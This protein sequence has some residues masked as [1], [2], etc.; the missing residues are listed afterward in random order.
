MVPAVVYSP[1][2]LSSRNAEKTRWQ[3]EIS[4]TG[5]P[6]SAVTTRKNKLT[7]SV[8]CKYYLIKAP[9]EKQGGDEFK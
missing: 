3:F 1:L 2:A 7:V 9:I 5:R 4:G 6:R 8:E